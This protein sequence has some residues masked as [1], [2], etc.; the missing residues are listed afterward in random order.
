MPLIPK[1]LENDLNSAIKSAYL[2]TLKKGR[3][4]TELNDDA[5]AETFANELAP[6]IADAID[7]YIKTATI[8]TPVAGVPTPGTII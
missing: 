8:V 1:V 6:A 5:I 7:K 3:T 2:K 4:L